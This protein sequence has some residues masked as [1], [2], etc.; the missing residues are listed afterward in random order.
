MYPASLGEFYYYRPYWSRWSLQ[1]RWSLSTRRS[2]GSSITRRSS[3]TRGS[4]I[5][6][7]RSS[8]RVSSSVR[9]S[10]TLVWISPFIRGSPI[11]MRPSRTIIITVYFSVFSSSGGGSPF[12]ICISLRGFSFSWPRNFMCSSSNRISHQKRP[13]SIQ[14]WHD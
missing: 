2:R 10:S 5:S 8:I 12:Y 9:E 1:A 4:S 14:L 13:R 7:R 3:I 11:S 6:I